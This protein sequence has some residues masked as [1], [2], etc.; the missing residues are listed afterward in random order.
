MARKAAKVK[1]KALG[2]SHANPKPPKSAP[3]KPS[4]GSGKGC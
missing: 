3:K 1:A 4:G 2:P